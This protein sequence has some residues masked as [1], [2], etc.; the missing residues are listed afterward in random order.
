MCSTQSRND[1]VEHSA[2]SRAHA[3]PTAPASPDRCKPN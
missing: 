3:A 1:R 2:C